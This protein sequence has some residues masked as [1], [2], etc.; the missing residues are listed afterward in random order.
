MGYEEI[1]TDT[2]ALLDALKKADHKTRTVHGD[3]VFLERALFL[4]WWCDKASCSFCYM[5]TQKGRIKKDQARRR[6]SSILAEAEL[7]R[8]IGWRIGFIS[9]GYGAYPFD[10]LIDI[11]RRV[12]A[13]HG[14]ATWLN[15]GVLSGDE[16]SRFDGIIEGVVGSVETVNK[17]LHEMICPGK[18]LD[19]VTA[20]LDDSKEMG[21]KIGM[22]IILGVG[23]GVE[24]LH[25]L[26]DFVRG[27]GID[28]ITVYS[29]N[30]HES[31]PHSRTPP[32]ASLYMAGVIAS[33][34]LE[35]P[36][37]EITAGTWIDQLS[38]I[39]LMLL[40]G[41]NSITKYP[42]FSMFGNRY[43]KKVEDEVS[44]ASRKLAGTFTD[45]SRL[46]VSKALPYEDGNEILKNV[47][48]YIERIESKQPSQ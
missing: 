17:E 21:F 18:P 9:G 33:L 43:G 47:E 2:G 41:A 24:D 6:V 8:R 16:I 38:N 11:V 48:R 22:N 39:G 13:I 36:R 28:K 23:E 30:P 27:H 34:R 37:L 42:F 10:E 12:K 5:S 20:M 32:P 7:M 31:T 45:M 26:L 3:E 4:S 14:K 46:K 25:A 15:V 35:F 19:A 40:A 1:F 44:A 29:L